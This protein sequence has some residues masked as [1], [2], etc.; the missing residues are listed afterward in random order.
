MYNRTDNKIKVHPVG[1]K[2]VEMANPLI[3]D[4]LLLKA[5]ENADGIPFQLIFGTQVG[6]G[7]YLRIGDGIR[8]LLGI[9]PEDFTEETFQKMIIN[10]TP[11]NN[12]IPS[13]INAAREKFIRGEISSYKAEIHIM[14]PDGTEKWLKDTS[15][16]VIDRNSGKVIGAFGI[17]TD[18]TPIRSNNG[19]KVIEEC[20]K[21]KTAFLRNISHEIRTPL[22]AIIGFSNLISEPGL[23]SD[24]MREYKKIIND[25]SDQLLETMTEIIEMSKIEAGHVN[26]SLDTCNINELINS[27]INDH[28]AECNEK[29][30]SIILNQSATSDTIIITDVSK[31]RHILKSLVKNAIKFTDSGIIEISLKPNQNNVE[32]SVKDNGIGIPYE[33]QDKLFSAFYQADSSPTRR[34]SGKGLGLTISKAYT[35]MLGGSIRCISSQGKGATFTIKLPYGPKGKE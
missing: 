29:G 9:E 14:T 3:L 23:R 30:I 33:Y 28:I 31:I 32:V 6:S 27:V 12:E 18:I 2:E 34:Y 20:E 25:S 5:I 13:D 10:I 17:L 4:T 19:H 26:M 8:K 15:I 1:R 21:L 7:H 11:E 16:P 35:E 24:M 22:N